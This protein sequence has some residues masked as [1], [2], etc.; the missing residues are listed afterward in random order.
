MPRTAMLK[1][2]SSCSEYIWARWKALILPWGDSMKTRTPCLPRIAYSAAE[3]VSPEVAPRMLISSPRLAST[4][5]KRLPSSC[6]AMS[7]KASVGP[8]D[9]SSRP[10]LPGS[11][12]CTGV[13]SDGL[14]P[15]RT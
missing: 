13:M 14:A 9:S 1:M 4:Y 11:S 10:S 7:L 15:S 12:Q 8:L 2:L 3:P 5:S 6:I